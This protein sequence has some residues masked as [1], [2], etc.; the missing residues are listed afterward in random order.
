MRCRQRNETTVIQHRADQLASS[1]RNTSAGNG[2]ADHV[3]EEVEADDSLRFDPDQPCI[4]SQVSHDHPGG[5]VAFK[6]EQNRACNDL[7][8][9]QPGNAEAWVR[10]RENHLVK[11][12]YGASRHSNSFMS[13]AASQAHGSAC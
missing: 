6:L 1:K 8:I 5:F 12:S 13:K 9:I 7:R 11:Q 2:G 4:S 3:I 10:Y